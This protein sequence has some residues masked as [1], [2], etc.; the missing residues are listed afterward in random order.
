MGSGTRQ[1][2]AL[3]RKNFIQWKRQPGCAVC[4]ICCPAVVMFL[5]V[6]LRS[7]ID[8]E[9]FPVSLLNSVR[10]PTMPGLTYDS[11]SGTGVWS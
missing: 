11:S 1:F 3:M 2:K 9:T 10:Q 8:I 7:V 5:L 4:E 6:I